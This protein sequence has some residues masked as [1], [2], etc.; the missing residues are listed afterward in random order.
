MDNC[1]LDLWKKLGKVGS[2][3][4]SWIYSFQDSNGG[5]LKKHPVYILQATSST[6]VDPQLILKSMEFQG[7]RFK[8]IDEWWKDTFTQVLNTMFHD[9]NIKLYVKQFW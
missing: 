2:R 8:F 5:P 3:V 9:I 4:Y 6:L 1:I 7:E